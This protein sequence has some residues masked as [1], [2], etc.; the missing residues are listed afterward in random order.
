MKLILV[1]LL[2]TFVISANA[3]SGISLGVGVPNYVAKFSP[4]GSKVFTL[5]IG[6]SAVYDLAGTQISSHK[7]A[8]KRTIESDVGY[9]HC[10]G[11]M[12]IKQVTPG[13]ATA[14]SLIDTNSGQATSTF[15][16][17]PLV[18]GE[19]RKIQ[20]SADC[21]RLF[22]SGQGPDR[23]ELI[24]VKVFDVASKALVYS[25]DFR[26]SLYF[27]QESMSPD[28]TKI[29]VND[30][31][32]F[33][34]FDISMGNEIYKFGPAGRLMWAEFAPDSQ[35]V[36]SITDVYSQRIH[37]HF[38]ADGTIEFVAEIESP[39]NPKFRFHP[40]DKDLI[41]LTGKYE[42][43]Q[44]Y[45]VNYKSLITKVF[46][47][48]LVGNIDSYCFD[49]SATSMVIMPNEGNLSIMDMTSGQIT[50]TVPMQLGRTYSSCAVSPDGKKLAVTSNAGASIHDLGVSK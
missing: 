36:I 38:L 31:Q 50:S 34:V 23:T 3:Q 43:S 6:E 37:R 42:N 15:E 16:I 7:S 29:L 14:V 25:K 20:F 12:A 18:A 46:S 45:F 26:S 10:S 47:L 19:V 30:Y 11:I 44:I 4:D 1:L 35:S 32:N 13:N 17:L 24:T 27:M 22:V 5:N 2:F 21:S 39:V 28:G 41:V 9:S 48:G 33:A 8:I 49:S 40:K